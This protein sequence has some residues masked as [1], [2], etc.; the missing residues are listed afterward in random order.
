MSIAVLGERL[1]AHMEADERIQEQR[2]QDLQS[3]R[4]DLRELQRIVVRMGIA[5]GAGVPVGST[6]LQWLLG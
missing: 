1:T 4:A 2:G 6:A 3:I 5:I